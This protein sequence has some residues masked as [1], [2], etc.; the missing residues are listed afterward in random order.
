MSSSDAT[1]SVPACSMTDAGFVAPSEPDI[2]AGVQADINAALGGNVN[3][4]LNTPQGQ[5][6]TSETAI[7]GDCND[8]LLALFN[9]FDPRNATGRM[10]D[11]L[12]YIYFMT[13]N[14]GE[15]QADFE[16]RREAT[17]E[18][19]S[20]G[21][22]ASIL[23]ALLNLTNVND[24]YVVDNPSDSDATIG[25]VTVPARALFISVSG[26]S[27]ADIGLAILQKKNPCS[28]TSGSSSVTVQD[29][30]SAYGGNGP[31]YTFNYTIAADTPVYIAVTIANSTAVPSTALTDIQTAVMAAFNGSDGGGRARIGAELFASRFYAGIASLGAWARIVEITIGTSASPVGFTAQMSIA[32]RPVISA[33][34]ITLNLV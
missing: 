16:A 11:A 21:T 2:L 33:D 5:L 7:I 22:N 14:T 10:Q 15:G 17:V 26:G 25:G 8:Q 3:P 13:R 6:A 30:N 32:Q 12:G 18:A 23:G 9:G 24:A 28:M 27:A 1:T 31:S 34:D 20:N 29:P 19:N 4:A